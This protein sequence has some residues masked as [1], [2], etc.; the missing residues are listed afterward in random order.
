M[1]ALRILPALAVA[2]LLTAAAPPSSAPLSAARIKEHVRILS[3]DAFL[4][5]GPTQP[6]EAKTI[7]YLARQFEAAGLRP[8]APNGS[9]YQ[10]VPL[11]RYDRGPVTISASVK[12]RALPLQAGR[13]VT[14]ASRIIGRTSLVDAPIVFAGYGVVAPGLGFDP[15]AGADLSGKVVLVLAGDPDFEAGRDLGFGGR[16]LAFAGR[17]GEKLAAAQAK[18]AL[19]VLTIHEE[20]AAS[21]PWSQV[22]NG[23]LLPSFALDEGQPLKSGFG[24]RGWLR[25]EVAVEI[26]RRA[27]LDYA[28]LKR[29]A[30]SP[31]FRAVALPD[32]TLS[33]QFETS[34]AKF[35]SRNVVGL[36]QGTS[37][38]G[39]T[40]LYGAHWDA[41][42]V[43]AFDPPSDRIRNGAIDNATGT[44]TLIEVA[45]AFAQGPSPQRT[46]LFAAWTAEEKGLLGASWYANHPLRPLATTAAVFN[47]DPHVALSAARN[48]EL[49][50]VGRTPL[51]QD[52]ARVAAVRGLRVDPE[53]NSEAGWYYRSDHFAF[54]QKGVPTVYFRAGRDL[55]RGGKRAGDRIIQRYNRSCY[56]Q[57]CDAFDRRWDMAGPAQ[58]GAVAYDVG[59]ELANSGRWPGWNADSDYGRFR[60]ASSGER[61]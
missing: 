34:V 28:R 53:E 10:E 38:A 25:R 30:Q 5:R 43:N 1:A 23:D 46:I 4:G 51:E 18:G 58:E 44:A 19:A 20:A 39:E 56:H 52:L 60:E 41:N 42:G 24:L 8:A 27:G 2:G 29:Q 47:L 14:A 26:L 32:A 57:T 33:V 21:Y 36:V 15:Y 59:R 61:R 49:I 11:I 50:G 12:G 6:G 48:L 7:D 45:R 54:A 17:T 55:V 35:V 9:W 3:S 37:R 13:D 22:Q 16:T 31:G 40:I